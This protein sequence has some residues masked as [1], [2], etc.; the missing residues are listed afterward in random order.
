MQHAQNVKFSIDI[1]WSVGDGNSRQQALL[2]FVDSNILPLGTL[3]VFAHFFLFKFI[4]ENNLTLFY[5]N[6]KNSVQCVG[7]NQ[8]RNERNSGQTYKC[9]YIYVYASWGYYL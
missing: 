2:L 6:N 7:Y 9:H 4:Q 5:N 8:M 3:V 1:G